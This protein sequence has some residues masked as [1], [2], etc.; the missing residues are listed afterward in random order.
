MFIRLR[1]PD[2]KLTAILLYNTFRRLNEYT[3][4]SRG[5]TPFGAVRRGG[6]RNE[7]EGEKLDQTFYMAR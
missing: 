6:G 7:G 3:L 5:F 1:S 2:G 4:E